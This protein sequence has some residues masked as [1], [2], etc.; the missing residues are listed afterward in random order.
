MSCVALA[1]L[2]AETVAAQSPSS[3]GGDQVLIVWTSGSPDSNQSPDNNV[4]LNLERKAESM[5]LRLQIRAFLARDFAQEFQAAL[6]AHLEPDII[7]VENASTIESPRSNP[8]GIVGIAS[9]PDVR[10]SLIQVNS[11]LNELAGIRG[12]WQFLISTSEHAEAARRFALRPPECDASL[13]VETPVPPDLEQTALQIADA[14]LRTPAEMKA[15]DDAD[16]LTTEG[17]R[18]DS[19]NVRETRTC[20]YWGND[21]LA[22]VSLVSTFEPASTGEQPAKISIAGRPLIGQM[23]ILLVLRKQEAQWRLL[24]ASSD[25]IS[26][27]FFLRQIP[28]ISRLLRKPAMEEMSI[29]P[30][31]LHSPENGRVPVPDAGQEFTW[32]PSPSG[33]VIAQ[34][35]EFAY[36]ND[37]RLFFMPTH[38]HAAPNQV[39]AGSLWSTGSEWK[40]RVWSI[41][42]TGAIVFSDYRMFHQ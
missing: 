4:P 2:G 20:G 17:V 6:A 5:G 1:L 31:Q 13:V 29:R 19:M 26:N 37:D 3:P 14:Y 24:V 28:A 42:D 23:P 21:R 27:G 41:S 11:S 33:N 36:M 9:D 10:R 7:A 35:V 18:W 40:W 32:Q 30:A 39:S 22:F 16:R 25:P 15:Y 8:Y 38:N 34:I 12:G